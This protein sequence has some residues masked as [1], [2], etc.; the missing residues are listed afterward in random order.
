MKRV[1]EPVSH[2]AS[3]NCASLSFGLRPSLGLKSVIGSDSKSLYM[4][5]KP[6]DLMTNKAR[7]SMLSAT[8]SELFPGGAIAP[9]PP[10]AAFS[11][12]T[13]HTLYSGI[14][15]VGSWAGLVS[16]LAQVSAK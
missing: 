2:Y 7:R 3:R 6:N 13:A 16:T 4:T 5:A 11:T 9:D 12:L 10:Q 8:R 14:F 15:A 1:Q